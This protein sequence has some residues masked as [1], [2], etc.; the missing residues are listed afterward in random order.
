MSGID[1]SKRVEAVGIQLKKNGITT[2]PAVRVACAIDVSG[3]TSPLF[4]SG[5][6][7]ETID[8]L[9]AVAVRFDDDGN[10]DAWAFDDEVS[11][12][13]VMTAKSYGT[14]ARKS[15]IDNTSISKWGGTHYGNAINAITA[16]YFP[17]L[18]T[19]TAQP[20]VESKPA[21]GFLGRLFGSK[22]EAA[23]AA[24]PQVQVTTKQSDP[25][26]VLFIT[27]GATSCEQDARRALEKAA[28]SPVYWQMVG[29][30][31]ASNFTFLK[32]VADD[33]PNVGFINLSSLS[34]TDEQLYEK[35]INPEFCQWIKA[36]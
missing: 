20:V 16:S 29:V 2:V 9:L 30:G 15:I 3:S 21:G 10:L 14:Y 17:E 28:G 33:L 13:P 35:L 34:M 25:A 36:R 5:V 31:P 4:S 22:P 24:A 18:N 23:P 19:Q 1:L 11:E 7:S 27:D 6:M 12:L 8:R 26:M 32:K